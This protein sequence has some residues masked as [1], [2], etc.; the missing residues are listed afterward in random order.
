MSLL[1]RANHCFKPFFQGPW[2][3]SVSLPPFSVSP[4]SGAQWDRPATWPLPGGPFVGMKGAL[5]VL[6]LGR[7]ALGRVKLSLAVESLTHST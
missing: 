7:E 4:G 5:R 6:G 1:L 2:G 3:F